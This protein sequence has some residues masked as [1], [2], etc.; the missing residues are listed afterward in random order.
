MKLGCKLV[1]ERQESPTPG[2]MKTW[3]ASPVTL[4]GLVPTADHNDSCHFTMTG[5]V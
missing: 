5:G 3:L 1:A 2:Q 4:D